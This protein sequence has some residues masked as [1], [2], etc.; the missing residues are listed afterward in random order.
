MPVGPLENLKVVQ[1]QLVRI[2]QQLVVLGCTLRQS[3]PVIEDRAQTRLLE[4]EEM[5]QALTR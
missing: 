1:Q 2:G 4:T 5:A 3:R